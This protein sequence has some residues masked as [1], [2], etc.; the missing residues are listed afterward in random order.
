MFPFGAM[1][2]PTSSHESLWRHASLPPEWHVRVDLHDH[3][4]KFQAEAITG[5]VFLVLT[6]AEMKEELGLSQLPVRKTLLLNIE[7][8]RDSAIDNECKPPGLSGHPKYSS[9]TRS[10]GPPSIQPQT[11]PCIWQHRIQQAKS[12]H[13][14]TLSSYRWGGTKPCNKARKGTRSKSNCV[15]TARPTT[16][17]GKR[18]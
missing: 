5:S 6:Q 4:G 14:I 1:R 9:R 10:P 11:S 8:L 13:K 16:P 15:G 3:A 2:M 18:T 12:S 17:P 7:V